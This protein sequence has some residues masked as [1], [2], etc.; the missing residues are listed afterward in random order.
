[1]L[2]LY[3]VLERITRAFP[4]VL[5]EGC[6]GGGGRFDAGMLY[7][8][9]QYWT[10]DDTDAIERL[11]IQH[12]TSLVMP[13]ITMGAHVSAVPNHQ[14]QRTTPLITRGH[15]AMAGQFGYEVDLNTLSDEEITLVREQIQ[16]YKSIRDAIHFGD[17]Y[18]LKSPFEGQNTAWEFVKDDR[19]IL[20]VSA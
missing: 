16:E 6:S 2:G 5:F 18:R 15:I 9:P 10:S 14:I 11:Y 19:V 4:N 20:I 3:D 12:G 13:P 17:M 1:M 7:Y 8:F